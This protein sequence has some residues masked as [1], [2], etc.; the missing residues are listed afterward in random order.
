MNK[1]ETEDM[2]LKAHIKLTEKIA[3]DFINL[4]GKLMT[5]RIGCFG[6]G[7]SNENKSTE[8]IKQAEKFCDEFFNMRVGHLIEHGSLLTQ[9]QIFPDLT[10]RLKKDADMIYLVRESRYSFKSL[11]D[12]AAFISLEMWLDQIKGDVH[13]KL[14]FIHSMALSEYFDRNFQWEYYESYGFPY[15]LEYLKKTVPK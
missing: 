2:A 10:L 12:A 9:T 5:H 1:L 14:R 11:T 8:A 3:L 13:E 4:S 6:S 7:L 15:T